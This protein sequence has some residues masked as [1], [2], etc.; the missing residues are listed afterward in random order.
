MNKKER[1]EEAS[2]KAGLS[3]YGLPNY[4]GEDV[5]DAAKKYNIELSKYRRTAGTG[6]MWGF[7]DEVVKTSM[8]EQIKQQMEDLGKDDY[9]EIISDGDIEI[10]DVDCYIFDLDGKGY[11]EVDFFDT[12]KKAKKYSN[13]VFMYFAGNH[14]IF[15]IDLNLKTPEECISYAKRLKS[16]Y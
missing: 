13:K 7:V 11:D 10:R 8:K 3:L 2:L 5:R 15:E 1:L 16:K 12:V 9:L 14:W 4:R 6:L